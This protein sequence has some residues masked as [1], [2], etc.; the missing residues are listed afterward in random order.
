M[1]EGSEENEKGE[2]KGR[3]GENEEKGKVFSEEISIHRRNEKNNGS[4][5]IGEA[6]KMKK[7]EE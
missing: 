7:N 3:N 2:E 4:N 1:E 6:K 5:G